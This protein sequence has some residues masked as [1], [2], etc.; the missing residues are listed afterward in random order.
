V[1]LGLNDRV[2]VVAGASKGIGRA[3]VV[4]LAQEGAKVAY[5]ARSID[6]LREIEKEVAAL[7]GE[8][9]PVDC[10]LAERDAADRFVREAVNAFGKVDIMVFTPSIHRNRE[11]MDLT[12]EQWEETF[13]TTFHAG[14]RMA[15]AVIPHMQAQKWGRIVFV[16]AGS[17]YKQTVGPGIGHTDVHPDFT[18][19][20]AALANLSKF[21]SK[22]YVPDQIFVN[23]LHPAFVGPAD[24]MSMWSQLGADEG[25]SPQEGFLKMASNVGY[26]PALARPGT[27]EGFANVIAFLCSEANEYVT[28][29]EAA[30]DG[31]GLDIG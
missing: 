18:T 25:L 14:V 23:T 9:L 20:K 30:I 21:L 3:T 31:G 8:C 15:R 1:D 13:N 12:D 7:G 5:C 4:R 24:R 26:I 17:V 10:D 16:G 28:G 29:I 27:S 22:N 19:A 11:F 6:T 2:A